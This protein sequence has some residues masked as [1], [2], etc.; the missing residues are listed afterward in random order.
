MLTKN[1]IKRIH[2]S[3]NNISQYKEK[4]ITLDE[5]SNIDDFKNGTVTT[6]YKIRL[7]SEDI[8]E[9]IIYHWYCKDEKCLKNSN[10]LYRRF[11]VKGYFKSPFEN[12]IAIIVFKEK[13]G[14]GEIDEFPFAVGKNLGKG[15]TH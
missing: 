13:N 10:L 6:D 7:Y 12:R 15:R 4:G 11:I 1:K 5:K 3:L 9:K 2:L 14:Y 8:K